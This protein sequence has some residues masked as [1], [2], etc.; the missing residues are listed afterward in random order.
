MPLTDFDETLRRKDSMKLPENVSGLLWGLLLSVCSSGAEAV[1]FYSE[2]RDTQAQAVKDAWAKV[3]LKAVI[4]VPRANLSSLLT[5]QLEAVNDSA[6]ARQ[7]AIVQMIAFS[8]ASKVGIEGNND[9]TLFGKLDRLIDRSSITTCDASAGVKSCSIS[10]TDGR[11]EWRE[12]LLA[13]KTAQDQLDALKIRNQRISKPDSCEKPGDDSELSNI[14]KAATEA[15]KALSAFNPNALWVKAQ[16]DADDASSKLASAQADAEK[17]RDDISSDLDKVSKGAGS[18]DKKVVDEVAQAAAR[19]ESNLKKLLDLQNYDV[20]HFELLSKVKQDSLNAF[21]ATLADAKDGTPPPA[22]SPKAAMAVVLFSQFFDDT[23]FT[24]KQT[25]DAGIAPIVL[26]KEVARLQQ[27]S[28]AADIGARKA[29]VALLQQRAKVLRDQFDLFVQAEEAR[30]SLTRETSEA[31]VE[32]ALLGTSGNPAGS[33]PGP[34]GLQAKISRKSGIDSRQAQSGVDD[35]QRLSLWLSLGNY[36]RADAA[37]ASLAAIDLKLAAA[38][39]VAELAYTEANVN[40]WRSLIDVHVNQLALWSKAGI[41]GSDITS[42][43]QTIAAWWI[44]NGVNK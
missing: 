31:R 24:L 36:F 3:D 33:N 5:R 10:T 30:G 4:E 34:A 2:A 25:E 20:F 26:Q 37:Q 1:T 38:D 43:L 9:K 7:N 15:A 8:N 23:K 40:A 27:E 16:K 41:K 32:D 35:D 13:A 22:T 28:A 29:R 44:A 18:N 12:R 19:L 17:I 14:C 6:A 39:R 11:G 42:A 21:L